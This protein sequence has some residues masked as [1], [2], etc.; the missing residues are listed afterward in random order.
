M[1][2][3]IRKLSGPRWG[4]LVRKELKNPYSLLSEITFKFNAIKRLAK[5][6]PKYYKL[7]NFGG[8]IN[9]SNGDKCESVCPELWVSD[10]IDFNPTEREIDYQI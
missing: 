10:L 4:D 5:N 7:I 6:Y 9:F 3:Y 2:T 8:F 1:Q